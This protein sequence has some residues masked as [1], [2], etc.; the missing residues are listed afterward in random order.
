M[1]AR[2]TTE[3]KIQLHDGADFALLMELDINKVADFEIAPLHVMKEGC[4]ARLAVFVTD[5]RNDVD[6]VVQPAEVSI[7]ELT[8][9]TEKGVQAHTCTK[10]SM[11]CGQVADLMW[12]GDALFAHVQISVDGQLYHSGVTVMT[13]TPSCVRFLTMA[14]VAVRDF[15]ATTPKMMQVREG[16]TLQILKAHPAGWSLATNL[17]SGSP[18]PRWVPSWIL[19]KLPYENRKCVWEISAYAKRYPIPRTIFYFGQCIGDL[20]IHW[21]PN[22]TFLYGSK[23]AFSMVTTIE[24]FPYQSYTYVCKFY[25]IERCEEKALLQT[26]LYSLFLR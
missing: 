6:A 25:A 2:L 16:D 1:A 20:P 13:A 11:P 21:S 10:L 22:P 19:V 17:S 9:S 12:R 26:Q 15:E 24:R 8:A 14:G 18:R 5:Q 4:L 3:G 23:A 7:L